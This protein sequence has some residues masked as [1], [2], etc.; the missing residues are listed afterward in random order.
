MFKHYF[1]IIDRYISREL[2][3]TWLAVTLILMLIL[4][5]STLARLLGKAADGVLPSD[6]VLPL[7]AITG[8]RYLILLIPLS[9]YLSVLL[10]FSRLYKDN[11]MAA[12]GACGVGFGRLYK[13]LMMVVIPVTLL[14]LV[15]TLYVMPLISQQAQIFKSEIESRS[16]LTGL[17]AGRFNQSHDGEAIMFLER[18]SR[19]GKNMENVFLNQKTGSASHIETASLAKRYKDEKGRK[20]ILFMNGQHYEGTPGQSNY[21]I[22]QYEKHGIYIPESETSLQRT[23]RDS[24]S[25]L[26]LWNSDS[27]VYQ[28][29]FQW[30]L[31]IPVA[32]LLMAVLALPLSYTTPR[33]GRYSKL[34]LAIL[35]YLIYSNLLGVGQTWVEQQKVPVWL[36]MWWVHVFGLVLIVYWLLK[37]NG[38]FRGLYIRMT[39]TK[40][41]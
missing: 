26:E 25:T 3:L 39:E 32:T 15:M 2:L 23:R 34:A 37:R 12:L 18:Q 27:A 13:P 6:A 41:A 9:L 28:A 36:G 17:I 40:A 33:K 31:S 16:E 29:E 14:I 1:S 20:F 24:V 8:A 7:L 19:D 21:Q 4:I 30:R 11:E 5:S 22:T 10:T 38:G 35:I